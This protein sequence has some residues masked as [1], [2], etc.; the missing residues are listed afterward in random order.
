MIG[1]AEIH[2]DKEGPDLSLEAMERLLSTR[3]AR[4][5]RTGDGHYDLASAFQK[6]VRASDPSASV[7][8][9]AK[10]IDVGEDPVFLFRRLLVMASEEV[11]MAD[12]SALATVVAARQTYDMVG[13]PEAGYDRSG[14]HPCRNRH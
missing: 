11:G 12:P 5:D 1:Q 13:L 10:M 6:A 14:N 8:Y 9:A 4:H 2:L 3:L 7:M